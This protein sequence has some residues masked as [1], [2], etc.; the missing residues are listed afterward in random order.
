MNNKKFF[1]GVGLA[2]LLTIGAL[3]PS[4]AKKLSKPLEADNATYEEPRVVDFNNPDFV[5]TENALTAKSASSVSIHYHNGDGK[6]GIREMWIWC[7]GVNGSAFTPE[8]SADGKDM[9]VSFQ[10][11]GEYAG[12]AGKSSLWFIVKYLKGTEEGGGDGRHGVGQEDDREREAVERRV[13]DH[14]QL[15]HHR[16]Q[17]VREEIQRQHQHD[18]RDHRR[19]HP[20]RNLLGR[21]RVDGPPGAARR[22]QQCHAHQAIHLVHERRDGHRLLRRQAV[23]VVALHILLVFF[24]YLNFHT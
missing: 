9:T 4:V 14:R 8:V 17:P 23:F 11:T 24:R 3:T 13:A 15:R 20:A 19:E 6:C 18:F 16:R 22:D 12:F 21:Q 10:F 1:K 7:D 2:A 5:G